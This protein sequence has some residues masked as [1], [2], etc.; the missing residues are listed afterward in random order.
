[1]KYYVS[2]LYSDKWGYGQEKIFETEAEAVKWLQKE[3]DFLTPKEKKLQDLAY[4]FELEYDGD[5]E[6]YREY[7]V[8][9]DLCTREVMDLIKGEQNNEVG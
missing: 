8:L 3:W 6:E 5:L 7:G 4:V 2:N 1:M 9:D